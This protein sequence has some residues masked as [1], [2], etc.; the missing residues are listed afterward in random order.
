MGLTVGCRSGALFFCGTVNLPRGKRSGARALQLLFLAA[1]QLGVPRRPRDGLAPQALV[2][3][4][5]PWTG[6]WVRWPMDRRTPILGVFDEWGRC[7][8]AWG[9]DA[10]TGSVLD[11][12]RSWLGPTP[13][14]RSRAPSP[15]ASPTSRPLGHGSQRQRRL[16]AA[17]CGESSEA[18]CRRGR[19]LNKADCPLATQGID[20]R[21]SASVAASL[22]ART[23]C[24]AE[25]KNSPATDSST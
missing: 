18:T 8:G 11:Q 14:S 12:L 24:Q 15:R 19:T 25:R 4:W 7:G 13:Y 1:S 17:V 5:A 3:R 20:S 16:R 2:L 10:K 21:P 6:R 23:K 22:R 9:Q